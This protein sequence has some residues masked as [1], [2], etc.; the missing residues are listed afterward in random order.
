MAAGVS[1]H[2]RSNSSAAARCRGSKRELTTGGVTASLSS[3]SERTTSSGDSSVL[4]GGSKRGR[5]SSQ[6]GPG[7]GSMAVEART[8]DDP[9]RGSS[10]GGSSSQE[11]PE[12]GVSEAIVAGRGG[13]GSEIREAEVGDG[14]ACAGADGVGAGRHD[15]SRSFREAICSAVNPGNALAAV[16]TGEGDASAV[17]TRGRGS[18]ER[19]RFWLGLSV[20]TGGAGPTSEK[21]SGKGSHRSSGNPD[22]SEPRDGAWSASIGGKTGVSVGGAGVGRTGVTGSGSP[23]PAGNCPFLNFDLVF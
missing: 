20:E 18:G 22:Q 12:R 13:A 5:S 19:A 11:G 3:E 10:S 9:G 14:C 1:C 8:L 4:Y 7:R 16:G 23:C 6:E 15:W 21:R 17:P 2:R